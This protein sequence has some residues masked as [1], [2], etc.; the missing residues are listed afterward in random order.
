MQLLS[1]SHAHTDSHCSMSLHHYIGLCRCIVVAVSCHVDG[2]EWW[3]CWCQ[4]CCSRAL[5]LHC[6]GLHH[7]ANTLQG[8]SSSQLSSR[9]SLQYWSLCHNCSV[10]PECVHPAALQHEP[11]LQQTCPGC[12]EETAHALTMHCIALLLVCTAGQTLLPLHWCYLLWMESIDTFLSK[13][14]SRDLVQPGAD[15]SIL[16][17]GGNV[18]WSTVSTATILV[19]SLQ[20]Q[21]PPHCLTLPDGDRPL[22]RVTTLEV[23]KSSWTWQGTQEQLSIY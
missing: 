13:K 10:C 18:P 3:S 5:P 1:C 4:Q 16:T 20:C 23:W 8:E 9:T 21:L 15:W 12:C 22:A 7:T 2:P 19:S 14:V 11:A 17:Q 6:P